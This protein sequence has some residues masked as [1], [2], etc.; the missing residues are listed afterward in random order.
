MIQFKPSVIGILPRNLLTV[1]VSGT[2]SCLECCRSITTTPALTQVQKMTKMRVVD[3][4]NLGKQAMLEGKAPKVIH[5][6]KKGGRGHPCGLLGDK[7]MVAIKGQKKKGIIIGCVQRQDNLT[8]KFDSN[9]LVL[10]NDEGNPLGTRILAPVP[11]VL[12]KKPELQKLIAIATT[13][14]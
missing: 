3:N 8:P 10:I 1:M 4:S 11:H 7:V 13:F 12:R 9:N 5:V 6:Y 14:V 2:V